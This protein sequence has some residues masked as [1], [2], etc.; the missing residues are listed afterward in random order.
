MAHEIT[1]YFQCMRQGRLDP[2]SLNA[3][4]I[5]LGNEL[6]ASKIER[7][8]VEAFCSQQKGD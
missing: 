2:D 4:L 6:E 7:L 5:Y 8:F 1:H 3:D